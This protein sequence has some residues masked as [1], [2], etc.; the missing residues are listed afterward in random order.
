MP[1]FTK[2]KKL[3]RH[4]T[5]LSF[6]HLPS[7]PSTY[8]LRRR[9]EPLLFMRGFCRLIVRFNVAFFHATTPLSILICNAIINHTVMLFDTNWIIIRKSRVSQINSLWIFAKQFDKIDGSF[10]D[11]HSVKNIHS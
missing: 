9:K 8:M 3:N 1:I 10:L 7:L 11:P 5:L 2:L 4:L 6:I